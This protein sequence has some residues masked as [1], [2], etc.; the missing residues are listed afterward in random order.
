MKSTAPKTVLLFAEDNDTKS[1]ANDSPVKT[2]KQKD[3]LNP[4]DF[5][6]DTSPTVHN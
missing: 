6:L 4:D 5:I 2:E 3:E 1:L